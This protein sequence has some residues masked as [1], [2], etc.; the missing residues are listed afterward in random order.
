MDLSRL[1]NELVLVR[2]RLTTRLSMGLAELLIRIVAPDQ[3]VSMLAD[4]ARMCEPSCQRMRIL[5]FCFCCLICF[6]TL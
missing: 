1:S 5:R 3:Q 6:H 4:C 2:L